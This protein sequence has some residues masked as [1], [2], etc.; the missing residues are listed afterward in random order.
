MKVL[1]QR[2]SEAHVDVSGRTVGAIDNGLLL[3]IGIEKH[4]D[5]A[6]VDR[7]VERIIGYRV[8]ADERG[9]MNWDVRDAGGALLAIS[10]FTLVADTRKGR[11][12]SFSSAADPVLARPLYEHCV[13]QLKAHGLPV[14]TGVFAAEMQVSLVNDGPVT[15]MLEM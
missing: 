5:T 2:V 8:F 4:D 3:F 11:R 13:A 1:M 9:K 14:A 10:Q 12:P 7:M 6:L 15:F